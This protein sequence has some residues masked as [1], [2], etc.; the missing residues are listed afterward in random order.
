MTRLPSR[1]RTDAE[2]GRPRPPRGLRPWPRTA[3]GAFAL[4]Q[5][6]PAPPPARPAADPHAAAPDPH[7]P[8]PDPHADP[9]L[10]G[11]SPPPSSPSRRCAS[12]PPGSAEGHCGRLR[13]SEHPVRVPFRGRFRVWPQ[14]AEGGLPGAW[15]LCF[16]APEEA[17]R[18]CPQRP[19]QAALPPRVL[20]ALRVPQGRGALAA[21]ST[22]IS[23]TAHLSTGLR[24]RGKRPGPRPVFEWTAGFLCC[25]VV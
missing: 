6:L 17:P 15:R 2:R 19:P 25:R 14:H 20:P 23:L 9:G 16:Q 5:T 8:A 21:A 3:A 13:R 12:S 18:C 10:R 4:M 24:L 22:R 11:V 1:C 7:A